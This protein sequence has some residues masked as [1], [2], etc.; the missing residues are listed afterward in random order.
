MKEPDLILKV[1]RDKLKNV[2]ANS[3]EELFKI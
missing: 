3:V 2:V 1:D